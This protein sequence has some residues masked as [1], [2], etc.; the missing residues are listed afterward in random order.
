MKRRLF[1]RRVAMCAAWPTLLRS[2]TRERVPVIGILRAESDGQLAI[3][4]DAYR[5]ALGQLGYIEGKSILLEYRLVDSSSN[6]FELAAKQL[7]QSN[8]S[9]IFALGTPAALAARKATKT[10]PILLYVADPIG[11]G[12]ISSLAHPGENITGVATMAE[13]TGAKRI[14]LLKELLP[15]ATRFGVLA[16][17]DNPATA[18]QLEVMQS[19]AKS[20]RVQLRILEIRHPSD[21]ER[22]L[23]A[24]SNQAIEA[25][26]A[27]SDPIFHGNQ[28]LLAQYALKKK[29]PSITAFRGYAQAGG[30]MSYGPDYRE[31]LRRCAVYTDKILK[32]TRAA[33]LPVEQP[34]KFELIL[35]QKTAKAL[36]LN[37]PESILLRVD[38]VIR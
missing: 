7:V 31:L 30:L 25:L 10:I 27:I 17:P 28:K 19:A 15:R 16:N 3:A 32:G 13:E 22:M 24:P 21:L 34:I 14:E 23:S 35:N 11:T 20:L 9:I 38:E 5:E 4:M 8:I 37:I 26:A 18:R 12:L 29:I 36:G 1:L 2:E 6:N 33:E